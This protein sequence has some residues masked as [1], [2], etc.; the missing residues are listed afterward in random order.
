MPLFFLLIGALIMGLLSSRISITR[1]K[2]E[3]KLPTP[4]IETVASGLKKNAIMEIDDDVSERTVGWTSFGNPF[5]P[6]FDGSTFAIGNYFIFSLRIDRKS[7]SSKLIKKYFA[8]EMMK[9]LEGKER[10]F[11]TKNEKKMVKERVT[12]ILG[13]RIPATPN[14][15][16]LIW[17]Y[18]ESSLLF[19]SSLKPPN[20]ELETLFSRSFKLT[21]IKLFPY[22]L[23]DLMAGLSSTERDTLSQLA[24]TKFAG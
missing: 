13:L 2:V 14:I 6:D 19:F 21:L 12:N 15:Y 9:E 17:N 4:V 22:T 5:K 18:E 16:D 7:I 3:G 8:I 20:E 23:G 24:P 10:T 11:L 1:Y